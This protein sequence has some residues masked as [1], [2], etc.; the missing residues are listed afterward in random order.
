MRIDFREERKWKIAVAYELAVSAVEWHQAGTAEQ[1]ERLGISVRWIPPEAVSLAPVLGTERAADI[2]PESEPE[3]ELEEE[4]EAEMELSYPSD[5]EDDA[6]QQ[7]V[8]D[9]LNPGAVIQEELDAVEASRSTHMEGR[10]RSEQHELKTEDIED[11]SALRNALDH[12][13]AVSRESGT[14]EIIAVDRELKEEDSS[15]QVPALRMHSTNPMLGDPSTDVKIQDKTKLY[16]PLREH[17]ACSENDLLFL[18]KDDYKLISPPTNDEHTEDSELYT[19]DLLS[20]FAD[21]QPFTL[22]DV[23][24]PSEVKKKERRSDDP[25]KRTEETTYTRLMPV[26]QFMSVK[27]TLLSTLHPAR[28]WKDNQW[29]NLENIPINAEND[30]VGSK[31]FEESPCSEKTRLTSNSH[32][33]NHFL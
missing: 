2:V 33:I 8:E 6:P 29:S 10:V 12:M 20:L 32:C 15:L 7:P 21:L 9:V 24:P 19:P 17:V 5:Q 23:T 4:K 1:R 3:L 26:S 25:Y 31:S 11:T 22:M 28:H 18:T 30:V 16:E 13:N 14:G 27:P